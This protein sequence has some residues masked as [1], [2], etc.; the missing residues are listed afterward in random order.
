MHC[1]LEYNCKNSFTPGFLFY[2]TEKN[3]AYDTDDEPGMGQSILTGTSS[4]TFSEVSHM[5]LSLSSLVQV[6]S[7][8][9]G[10]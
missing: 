3:F 9:T 4:T 10:A 6:K 2:F 8:D 5:L 7:V 1:R